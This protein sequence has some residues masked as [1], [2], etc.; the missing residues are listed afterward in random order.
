MSQAP[1]DPAQGVANDVAADV[2][3][4]VVVQAGVVNGNVH[5]HAPGHPMP[6]LG[7]FLALL[8]VLT[9]VG[10][11]LSGHDTIAGV[12]VPQPGARPTSQAPPPTF[13]LSGTLT[14]K[15]APDDLRYGKPAIASNSKGCQGTGS[16]ADLSAGTAVV[17]K[18]P[19]GRQVAV[20]SLQ[21]GRLAD[22]DT[23]SCV[24]TFSVPDV[25]RDLPSYSVTISRRGTRVSTPEEAQAGIALFIG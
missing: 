8:A 11:T 23:V 6:W 22:G 25:P 2:V 12:P 13:T 16:Y 20:G 10:V 9:A 5:V 4:G 19:A 17:I 21:A 1:D 3:S 18:D 15:Q 7:V 14:L 24:M